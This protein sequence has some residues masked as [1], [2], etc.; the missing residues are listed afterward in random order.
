MICEGIDKIMEFK[1]RS[2]GHHRQPAPQQITCI[3]VRE[4]ES[5]RNWI[6]T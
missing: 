5:Y 2:D 4:I 3:F 1:T 6:N